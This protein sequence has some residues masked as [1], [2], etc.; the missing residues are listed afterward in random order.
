MYFRPEV[1]EAH[2][3]FWRNIRERLAKFGVDAPKK[4]SSERADYHHWTRPD[5]LL[6]QT[7][8]LPYRR[9][10]ADK[11]KLV[12]TPDYQIKG[13]E[14]GYYRSYFIVR[15]KD[16]GTPFAE[17]LKRR[18]A[19]NST[20]SQ[21]GYFAAQ[22][23]LANSGGWF[24]QTLETGAHRNSAMAVANSEADIACLDA[25]SWRM[26]ERYDSFASELAVID[27]T[28]PT[29][30]LPY[31]CG[32]DVDPGLIFEAVEDAIKHLEIADRDALGISGLTRI[33]TQAYLDIEVM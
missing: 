8:G 10:L 21:S 29:P 32:R 5:L 15:R 18:F 25:V 11:V 1:A 14:A 7:C 13:C 22:K 3:R 12:G 27:E 9:H 31:I 20:D 4:L 17:F 28:D 24:E 6:S 2:H 16:A 33:S 30:G 23:H 19:Y 26:M